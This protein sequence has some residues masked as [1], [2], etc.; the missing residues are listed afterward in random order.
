MVRDWGFSMVFD[1]WQ[2]FANSYTE[3]A[4]RLAYILFL[5]SF[6]SQHIDDIFGC[7]VTYMVFLIGTTCT[8]EIVR[9]IKDGWDRTFFY[10]KSFFRE[11]GCPG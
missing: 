4:F 7:T 5:T 1:I 10:H 6:A 3:L 11:C 2:M 9:F 8:V